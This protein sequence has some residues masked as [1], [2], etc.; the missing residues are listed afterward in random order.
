MFRHDHSFTLF[1]RTASVF[2]VAHP[3]SAHAY[4]FLM[5]LINC[6]L[7]YSQQSNCM[8]LSFICQVMLL[9]KIFFYSETTR[10]LFRFH[11]QHNCLGRNTGNG[12]TPS[13]L[14]KAP[15]KVVNHKNQPQYISVNHKTLD[16]LLVSGG[17]MKLFSRFFGDSCR[18]VG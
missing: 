18:V 4:I 14:E 8:E 9:Q 11:L 15:P 5:V 1:Q 13:S 17:K 2:K 16:S 7:A 10:Y 3:I 6:K 12:S